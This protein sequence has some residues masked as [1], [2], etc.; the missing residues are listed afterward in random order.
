MA[1]QQFKL[2]PNKYMDFDEYFYL[3]THILYTKLTTQKQKHM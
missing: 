1:R 2:S 3:H